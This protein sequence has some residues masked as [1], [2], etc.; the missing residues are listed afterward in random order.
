M[1]RH[2]SKQKDKG[3][4]TILRWTIGIAIVITFVGVIIT[5][6]PLF[7]VS[8]SSLFDSFDKDLISSYGALLGGLLGSLCS[9]ASVII[10]LITLQEERKFNKERS[11]H[12]A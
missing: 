4:S 12:G 3:M 9:S 10:L 11:L 2:S 6:S 5:C 1:C 8:T 7:N